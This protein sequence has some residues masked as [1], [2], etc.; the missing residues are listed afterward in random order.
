MNTKSICKIL[1][2][3]GATIMLATLGAFSTSNTNA[4]L[5]APSNAAVPGYLTINTALVQSSGLNAILRTNGIIPTDGSGGAFGYGIVT[6]AGLSAVIVSTTH[7][8]VR[9][10]VTQGTGAGPIWHNHFVRLAVITT[11]PCASNPQVTAIT[12][13][14]PGRVLISG[15]N[16]YLQGIPSSFTGT[17]A[18]TGG[19]LTLSPGHNVQNVVSFVLAP[20]FSGGALKAVCV[21]DITPAQHVLKS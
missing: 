12:F 21:D 20:M 18:L 19:P 16:A 5:I 4:Q 8:G 2:V 7:Q 14:Q 9:D 11:G 6:T 3:A 17:D 1:A 13:Q 15:S 10:S